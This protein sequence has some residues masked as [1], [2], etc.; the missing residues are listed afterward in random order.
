MTLARGVGEAG[1]AAVAR[2]WPFTFNEG[3]VAVCLIEAAVLVAAG[4]GPGIRVGRG[5]P[6][7]ICRFCW[8]WLLICSRREADMLNGY[9]VSA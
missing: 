9:D 8:N 3:G 1:E 6:L 7:R 5:R 2:P 4:V